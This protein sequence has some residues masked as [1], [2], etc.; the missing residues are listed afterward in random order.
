MRAAPLLLTL[1]LILPGALFAEDV[2][3]MAGAEDLTPPAVAVGPR[4]HLALHPISLLGQGL[5][6]EAER[7][8]SPTAL[9]GRDLDLSVALRLGGRRT[10]GGTFAGAGGTAGLELKLWLPG[11]GFGR[12]GD[13]SLTGPLVWT[14]LDLGL[15]ALSD[16]G[17]PVGRVWQL[18]ASVGLGYRAALWR[19]LCLTAGLGASVVHDEGPSGLPTRTGLRPDLTLALGWVF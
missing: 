15:T 9:F 8:L 19:G 7:R 14:R 4:T 12:L 13:Q 1:G 10:A 16:A 2:P 18:G 5:T 11:I 17:G 3:E 6:L